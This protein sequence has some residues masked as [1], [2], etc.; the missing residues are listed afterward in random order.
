MGFGILFV[1]YFMTYLMSLNPFGAF[2]RMTGYLLMIFACRRLREYNKSFSIAMWSA[3]PLVLT[4]LVSIVTFIDDNYLLAPLGLPVWLDGA[5]SVANNILIVVFHGMLLFAIRE[6]AIDTDV[7]KLTLSAVRNFIFI[8]M[9]SVL[10]IIPSLPI[11]MLED[12]TRYFS[13][14][15][16][17]FYLVCIILN[18]VLIFG[19]YSNI[20]D[21]G[22][23]E[24][25]P[26]KSRF[27]FINKFR[28]ETARRED[29]AHE[30]S[31]EYMRQRAEARRLRRENKRN[32]K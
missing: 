4:S 9:Y 19:C 10:C 6:I 7:E 12:Y 3:L 26:R 25:S 21:E 15:T 20:C 29:K 11:K 24:M 31:M 16:F 22:D 13:L 32:R 1:G 27:E 14:P 18:L 28:E 17:V 5:V 30:E 2:F 8:C 23:M